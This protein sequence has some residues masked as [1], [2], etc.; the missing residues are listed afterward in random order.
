M[1]IHHEFTGN[2]SLKVRELCE[3]TGLE[4]LKSVHFP[5]SLPDMRIYVQKGCKLQIDIAERKIR[6]KRMASDYTEAKCSIS[7]PTTEKCVSESDDMA[8]KYSELYE[9]IPHVIDRLLA[10]GRL[11]D[12]VAV[13][14]A[15]N[16]GH[17]EQN[18]A[19]H[20]LLDV[21]KFYSQ[22]GGI[23][24]MRYS[25][26][27][28]DFWATVSKLFKGRG[29]NFFRGFKGQGIG[30]RGGR[31]KPEDCKINVAVPSDTT[32][33]KFASQFTLD[34]NNPGIITEALDSFTDIKKGADV[35]LSLDGNRMA[36]RD[37]AA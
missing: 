32:L 8:T 11:D 37:C 33:N 14:R 21:G 13:L 30:D 34:I 27:T 12:F 26:D 25:Q 22:D 36:K 5:L 9:L 29:I 1:E 4:M 20:L 24:Q 15:L 10:I 28:M 18:I 19:L 31:I 3:L 35:K 23:S 17:L 16:R 2:F 6:I 7:D